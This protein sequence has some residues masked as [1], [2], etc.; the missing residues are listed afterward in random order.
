MRK[1]IVVMFVLAA[2]NNSD[3][4]PSTTDELKSDQNK[5]NDTRTVD[6]SDT[7]QHLDT[8]AYKKMS[9]TLRHK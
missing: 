5:N 7:T 8:G 9:D 1:I 6:P 4:A 3:P 2:C